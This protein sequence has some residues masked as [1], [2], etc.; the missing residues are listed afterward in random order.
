MEKLDR[1]AFSV[2]EWVLER[3]ILVAYLIINWRAKDLADRIQVRPDKR[4]Y[5]V[6][7]KHLH[8]YVQ[9]G[10]M[11]PDDIAPAVLNLADDYMSS[12]PGTGG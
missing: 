4:F 2:P 8:A 6:V 11:P 7:A 1:I 5:E 3:W 10:V 12:T 9:E